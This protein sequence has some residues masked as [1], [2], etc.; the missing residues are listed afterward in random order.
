MLSLL[1][2]SQLAIKER[3]ER[4]T[5]KLKV[6]IDLLKRK[7][8][9]RKSCLGKI[10]PEPCDEE[11]SVLVTVRHLS[12]GRVVRRFPTNCQVEAVYNWVGALSNDPEVFEL[13]FP[14]KF[15]P[16]SKLQPISIISNVVLNMREG[17]PGGVLENTDLE[18]ILKKVDSKREKTEEHLVPVFRKINLRRDNVYDDLIAAYVQDPELKI[19]RIDVVFEGEHAS[20]DGLAREAFDIFLTEL[21]LKA[22]DGSEQF[23]PVVSPEM[24]EQDY[25]LLGEI[26]FHFYINFGLFPVQISQASLASIFG[27]NLCTSSLL[28]SF[29]KTISKKDEKILFE[30]YH[31]LSFNKMDITET[32]STFGIRSSPTNENVADLVLKA[33]KTHII[34]KP[35]FALAGIM[36]GFN[37]F[38]DDLP[39]NSIEAIYNNALPTN[40][41][42]LSHIDFP[43]AM[44]QLSEKTF[45]YLK[46]FIDEA[47]SRK[48]KDFMRFV[49]G[50]AFILGSSKIKVSCTTMTELQARP[51]SHTC[52]K[53]LMLSKCF[54]TYLSFK[55]NFEQYLDNKDYWVMDDYD[56]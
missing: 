50:S 38:F 18:G 40:Q 46:R 45:Q 44:D 21:F 6:A 1:L 37:G 17:E 24:S 12:L 39:K 33:A 10:L 53:T 15:S 3:M 7:E 36:K 22:F 20:G 27:N 8:E 49:T 28:E 4:E 52:V 19:Y 9:A 5:A 42:V 54:P 51:I 2:H 31:G 13:Y 25:I 32:L 14:L 34:T 16:V 29:F 23:V 26:I 48:L 41:S 35:S 56:I 11:E 55:N 43:Q 47:E 30:T